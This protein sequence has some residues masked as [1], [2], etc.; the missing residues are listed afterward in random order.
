[1][2]KTITYSSEIIVYLCWGKAFKYEIFCIRF[3]Q[4]FLFHCD[5]TLYDNFRAKKQ[6]R[7]C[8]IQELLKNKSQSVYWYI[9]CRHLMCN[10]SSEMVWVDTVFLCTFKL[11]DLRFADSKTWTLVLKTGT[12]KYN[13]ETWHTAYNIFDWLTVIYS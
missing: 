6:A 5:F 4:C 1:M 11:L 8:G 12:N 10:L 13:Y 2:P 7:N 9:L 3:L